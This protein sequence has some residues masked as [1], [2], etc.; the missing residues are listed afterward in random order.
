MIDSSLDWGLDKVLS[1]RKGRG[2]E[3]KQRKE[4]GEARG[5]Q[6]EDLR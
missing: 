3:G 4:G 6:K 5:I 2:R 1:L